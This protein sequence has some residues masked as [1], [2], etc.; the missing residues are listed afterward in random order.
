MC[1]IA[2]SPLGVQ[3]PSDKTMEAMFISNP[4]GAGF[5][6][7]L[8]ERVYVEKGFMSYKEFENALAGLE[9]RLKK[10]NL[11]CTDI[12]IFFHFRIGTHGATIPALTHPF[13]ISTNTKNLFA[14]DYATD[15]VMAHNGI[16]NSINVTGAHSDTTQYISKILVP[17]RN[18]DTEFYKNP[19]FQELMTNTIDGSRFIFLTDTGEMVT[20]G[21]WLTSEE[22][23][24]V[25]FSNLNHEWSFS[26]PR[27]KTRYGDWFDDAADG[28]YSTF[29][30]IAT[31]KLIPDGYYLTAED[32]IQQV[33]AG[34]EKY[35][36]GLYLIN[37][38]LYEQT[39]NVPYDFYV[40]KKYNGLII[41]LEQ[42]KKGEYLYDLGV[43]YKIIDEDTGLIEVVDFDDIE[44]DIDT[45][46]VGY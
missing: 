19:H 41:D 2:G 38:A 32:N 11:T 44:S 17:L 4:D 18:A 40:E 26:L 3:R 5:A 34:T 6:Y 42:T 23:P 45:I 12:P 28:Y 15:I 13:P 29:S 36:T 39:S 14:L 31:V 10:D 9:K 16:I 43:I 35:P 46:E 20:I 8:N 37:K 22:E 25:L 33:V 1:V 21:N 24:G 27:G 7:T 30:D